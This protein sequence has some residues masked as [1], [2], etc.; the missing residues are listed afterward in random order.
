MC[1]CLGQVFAVRGLVS[2]G[3]CEGGS[4]QWDSEELCDVRL[5]LGGRSLPVDQ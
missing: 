3:G 5:T 4:V 2:E 1:V